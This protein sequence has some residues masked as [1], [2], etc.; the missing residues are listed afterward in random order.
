MNLKKI[1]LRNGKEIV[2]RLINPGDSVGE[3]TIKGGFWVFSLRI[4]DQ[5]FGLIR[6]IILARL[7]S[8]NDFGLFGIALLALSMLDTFSQTGFRQALIQKKEETKST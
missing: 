1:N 7:L 8:P 5:L 2:R 6:I 3:K 4:I